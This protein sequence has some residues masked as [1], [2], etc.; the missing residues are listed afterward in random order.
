M[1][2]YLVDK[3]GRVEAGRQIN[4]YLESGKSILKKY[5]IF[6]SK[7]SYP[8][9]SIDVANELKDIDYILTDWESRVK[10][11]LNQI[12]EPPNTLQIFIQC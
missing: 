8:Y 7:N 12:F 2:P 11:Y 3:V 5:E 6:Y 10:E 1:R 9:K 4:S